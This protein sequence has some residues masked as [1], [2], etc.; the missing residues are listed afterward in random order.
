MSSKR[1]T[2]T[3]LKTQSESLKVSEKIGPIII[4]IKMINGVTL[5]NLDL[6]IIV[7]LKIKIHS[8]SSKM[9]KM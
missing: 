2:S 3:L 6:K 7:D 8:K 1:R 4:L 5:F 9:N